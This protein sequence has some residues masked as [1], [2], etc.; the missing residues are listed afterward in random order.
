MLCMADKIRFV[1]DVE[2]EEKPFAFLRQI[3][4]SLAF[5]AIVIALILLSVILILVEAFADLSPATL[6]TIQTINDYLTVAFIFEL[7]LR[8]LVS[9]NTR[10]FLAKFWIDILA[11]MPLLRVF[12][13][14]RVLRLLRLFRVFSLGASFQRRFTMFNKIIESR[15][16][17]YCVIASFIVFAVVF[18]AVGLSQFETGIDKEILT[19]IDAFWK[20]LFSLMAGEYADYPASLGGKF[21]FLI[22]LMFQMG[23]FAMLTG[24]FSAIMFEKLKENAMHKP[25]NPEDLKNHVI[26]C[27]YSGKVAVII[28]EFLLDPAFKNSEILLVSEI[29]D[30]EDL[31]QRRIKIERVSILKEDFTR[32]EVLKKAGVTRAS[33]AVILSEHGENR[34]TQDIDARTILAAL[35]IEKLNPAIHTSAE[36]YNEEYSSHLRMGGVDDV[37]IQGEFSGKLLAKI[38]ANEGLLEFFQDLLSRESGSTLSFIE[39]PGPTVGKSLKDANNWIQNE[40]GYIIVGVKPEKNSLLV[41]P[42]GHIIKDSDSILIINPVNES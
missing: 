11:V 32:M 3:V 22:L 28:T 42:K 2:A 35:T 33:A 31:K 24:T 23:V 6:I 38:S 30:L 20:S 15:M 36:I 19:P 13:L 21:V 10:S 34:T 37:V 14:A 25:T 40:C 29:A 41:N 26:I 12:R 9:H 7:T 39:P 5:S 8:W 18:G 17:E 4:D 1:H 16:V 27:G